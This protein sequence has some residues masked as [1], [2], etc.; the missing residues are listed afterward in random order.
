MI[1]RSGAGRDMSVALKNVSELD[2]WSGEWEWGEEGVTINH[3]SR[4][5]MISK[6]RRVLISRL[7]IVVVVLPCLL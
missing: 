1:N 2:P 6:R 5:P 3:Q 4:T 7:R